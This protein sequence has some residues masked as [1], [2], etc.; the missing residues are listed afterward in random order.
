MHGKIPIKLE[1][2]KRGVL[3]QNDDLYPVC[4]VSA[5]TIPHLFCHCY[6][7]WKLW[8]KWCRVWKV[9]IVMPAN[10]RE[11]LFQWKN[12]GPKC[13]NSQVWMM[14]FFSFT[15][16]IW[17]CRN[18][19]VFKGYKVDPDQ[20]FDLCVVRLLWWCKA[21]WPDGDWVTTDIISDPSRLKNV[22]LNKKHNGPTAWIAPALGKLKFNTYG[23]VN[24]SVG[25]A[26]IGGVL[27]DADS[28]ILM[29][30]SKALVNE[31][32]LRRNYW[33]Y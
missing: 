12:V 19:T 22:N 15:W 1:L 10:V 6:C 5:E 29:Y 11:L 31:T 16:T 21:R 8:S 32:Q 14:S 9:C 28:K 7:A 2:I 20:I 23:A 26:G 30:F 3:P 24:G 18:E 17:K 25:P 27:R 13:L 33:R 4:K